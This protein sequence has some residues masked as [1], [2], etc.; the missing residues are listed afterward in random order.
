[1]LS[2]SNIL[3]AGRVKWHGDLCWLHPFGQRNKRIGDTHHDHRRITNGSTDDEAAGQQDH[4][5]EVVA[6]DSALAAVLLETLCEFPHNRRSRFIAA[7]VDSQHHVTAERQFVSKHFPTS[8]QIAEKRGLQRD[9]GR[10]NKS[11]CFLLAAIGRDGMTQE[12]GQRIVT[13]NRA[14]GR[15]DRHLNYRFGVRILASI[16]WKSI[17]IDGSVGVST[18]I[19]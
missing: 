1:M 16:A 14:D 3:A 5:V 11:Q 4:I 15:K 7:A 9:A 19:S 6:I 12:R 10:Q 13:G 2:N 8:S 17:A 18:R